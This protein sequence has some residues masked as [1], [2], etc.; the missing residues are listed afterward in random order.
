MVDADAASGRHGTDGCQ[1]SGA[2]RVVDGGQGV[3]MEAA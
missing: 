1:E 2:S 3:A